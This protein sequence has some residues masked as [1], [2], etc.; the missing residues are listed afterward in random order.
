MA[1]AGVRPIREAFEA[2]V[3][4]TI[5][6]DAEAG[7]VTYEQAITQLPA[8]VSRVIED[9]TL[10]DSVRIIYLYHYYGDNSWIFTRL[11][12][13]SIGDGRWAFNRLAFADRWATVVV[14]TTPGFQSSHAPPAVARRR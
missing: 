9:V 5:P 1:L 3:G 14:A 2:L 4:G 8:R 10:A 7:I 11:E 13:I 12:F 6:A